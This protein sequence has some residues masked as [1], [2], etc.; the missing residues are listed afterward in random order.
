MTLPRTA[1]ALAVVNLA[2]LLFTVAQIRHTTIQDATPVV[3]ARTIELVDGAGQLRSRLN[4][5]DNGEVVLRL[6]DQ[7]ITIRVKL[8]A[9]HDGSG[10]LL[11]NDATEPG[12]HILA[13]AEGSN[14]SLR[15]KNGAELKLAP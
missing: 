9:A 14:L 13:K 1:L 15:D 12:I 4:L 7:D 5:E 3:R 8:G 6:L 2:L 10:L 11:N